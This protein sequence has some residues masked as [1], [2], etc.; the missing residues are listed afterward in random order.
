MIN[1]E[2]LLAKFDIIP[3]PDS[4][5]AYDTL[6][7]SLTVPDYTS[8]EKNGK[9]PHIKYF[10]NYLIKDKDGLQARLILIEKEYTSLSYLGDYM[11]YYATCYRGYARQCRRV[12]FFSALFDVQEFVDMIIQPEDDDRKKKWDSYLGFIVIKPLPA[13]IIGTTI[14]R[15]YG[16]KQRRFFTATRECHINLFGKELKMLTLPYQEQDGIVGTCASSALWFAFQKT[17]ELFKSKVPNPS[18]ITISAGYDSHHTGK[19]FPNSGLDIKQVCKAITAAGLVAELWVYDDAVDTLKDLRAFVYAYLKMGAPVLL[20][21]KLQDNGFH[22]VTLNGYRFGEAGT[23]V[24]EENLLLESDGIGKLYAH[25][26]Q[27]GP[28]ARLEFISDKH[29]HFNTTWWSDVE[30]DDTLMA[31]ASCV[32][33]P[34]PA[35]IKVTFNNIQEEILSFELMMQTLLLEEE[36]R[37]DSSDD[38]EAKEIPAFR[39]DIYLAESNSYKKEIRERLQKAKAGQYAK[40]S[41]SILFESLPRYIW[42]AKAY[43]HEAAGDF[44]M[45]DLIYDAIDVNYKGSPY[46]ANIYNENFRNWLIDSGMIDQINAFKRYKYQKSGESVSFAQDL[47]EK[48]SEFNPAQTSRSVIS[49]NNKSEQPK[50]TK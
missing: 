2:E 8:V 17:G 44:L 23:D 20:G 19:T 11:N 32:I 40:N 38:A 46:M 30:K 36:E 4:E 9:K 31:A 18:D 14:L 10:Y 50:T 13:G 42:V 28:F 15:T 16:E 45:F 1:R 29:Y 34:L 37:E 39:W 41:E 5:D 47:Y 22:L 48:T 24:P 25:D 7:R 12:H 26:D 49:D 27:A 21:I 33:V 6:V 43:L 35:T 3:I